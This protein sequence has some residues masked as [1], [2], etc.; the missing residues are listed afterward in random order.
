MFDKISEKINSSFKKLRG[1]AVISENNVLDSLKEI[2]LSL[3]EADVNYK[4]VKELID[5]IK[6]K[7]IGSEVLKSVSP[8]EQ[9]I[10]IFNKL[11]PPS[12]TRRK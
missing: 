3:L 1:N 6:E 2:R 7:A 5:T 11:A 8:A 4:V 12:F 9:F 10:K